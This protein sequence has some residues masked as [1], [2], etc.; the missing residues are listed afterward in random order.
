M[1]SQLSYILSQIAAMAPVGY[2]YDVYIGDDLKNRFEIAN[3]PARVINAVGFG[4]TMQRAQTFGA[5]HVVTTEWTITDIALIR[6]AG[7]GLGL[8]DI[9]DDITGYL[10]AYHDAI[11]DLVTSQWTLSRATMTSSVLEWPQGGGSYHDAVTATLTI[12]EIVQ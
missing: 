11:R 9:S 10:I 3:L 4:A 5:G 8:R 2:D 6:K 1:A 12:T 7:M